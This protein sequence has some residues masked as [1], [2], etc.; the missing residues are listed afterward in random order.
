[1]CPGGLEQSELAVFADRQRL[2]RLAVWHLVLALS[3]GCVGGP[4]V[5]V[6]LGFD[7]VIVAADGM[8]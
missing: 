1:V 7:R 2:A 3:C 6:L 5:S 4:F 8:A